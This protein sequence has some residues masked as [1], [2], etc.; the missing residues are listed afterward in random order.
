MAKSRY[1]ALT[2][3]LC[4]NK[5]ATLSS[6]SYFDL[7]PNPKTVTK[8]VKDWEAK[9]LVEC[10]GKGAKNRLRY[11]LTPLGRAQFAVAQKRSVQSPDGNM[12]TAM[13]QLQ[14]FTPVDIA[15]NATTDD[16]SVSIEDARAFC[17]F[18]AKGD[19]PY[20][21]VKQTAIP[22]KREAAYQLIRNTGPK[23]PRECRIR[24]TFDVNLGAFTHIPE[25]QQ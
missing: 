14:T 2:E 11:Q 8:V 25:P 10:L 12:W 21:R 20:L 15:V 22:G 4:R 3:Q 9:G 18:L 24:A 16:V 1:S 13:R 19:E 17:R 5:A 7:G 6:F 23:P